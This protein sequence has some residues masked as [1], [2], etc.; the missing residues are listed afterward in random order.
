MTAGQMADTEPND[1]QK[2]RRLNVMVARF[3]DAEA[4]ENN[5]GE[6]NES[7]SD[8]LFDDG[9]IDDAEIK[10]GLHPVTL[11][12]KIVH[13]ESSSQEPQKTALESVVARWEQAATAVRDGAPY[14]TLSEGKVHENVEPLDMSRLCMEPT[15]H[16]IPLW[17]VHVQ[18]SQEYYTLQVI[19]DRLLKHSHLAVAAVV[20]PHVQGSIL[21]ESP[22]LA[23][24]R[25]LC[26]DISSVIHSRDISL[27]P[28]DERVHW[29]ETTR[30][31]QVNE[32]RIPD[33]RRLRSTL[34][35]K[36]TNAICGLDRFGGSLALVC[37]WDKLQPEDGLVLN[38]KILPRVYQPPPWAVYD[39]N[40][41]PP[42]Q[43][44]KRMERLVTPFAW[45]GHPR[46][47]EY[48]PEFFWRPNKNITLED[49]GEGNYI[50]DHIPYAIPFVHFS[51]VPEAYF[52][53]SPPTPTYHELLLFHKGVLHDFTPIPR[54]PYPRDLVPFLEDSWDRYL[55]TP[56]DTGHIVR[57][58]EGQQQTALGMIIS[59][60]FE[61]CDVQLLDTN[62]T[63]KL[64]HSHLRR[65]WKL[66]DGARVVAKMSPHYTQV[67]W[68]IGIDHRRVTLIDRDTKAHFE[69]HT[70]QIE[71]SEIVET[72]RPITPPCDNWKVGDW[73]QTDQSLS[74]QVLQ[75]GRITNIDSGFIALFDPDSQ[76]SCE[77]YPW[78]IEPIERLQQSDV[79][80]SQEQE[81]P[82]RF[83]GGDP[84]RHWVGQRVLILGRNEDK[85]LRG[86]VKQ[87]ATRGLVDV[88][89]DLGA[90]IVRKH[91]SQLDTHYGRHLFSGSP[92]T[93]P[94][95]WSDIDNVYASES[96]TP[97]PTPDQQGESN[98]TRDL[99]SHTTGS[100]GP[101][102]EGQAKEVNPIEKILIRYGDQ[103]LP[104][105]WPLDPALENKR[106]WVYVHNSSPNPVLNEAGYQRGAYDKDRGMIMETQGIHSIKVHISRRR[107]VIDIPARFLFPE[108]PTSAKQTVVVMEGEHKGCV[109]NTRKS[110]VPDHFV[111]VPM[112]GHRLYYTHA[113][114]N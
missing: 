93:T 26:R 19:H 6:H 15:I 27:V 14:G 44:R 88:E 20:S 56:L 77:V 60:E 39:S 23:N 21:V 107:W 43:S 22:N 98:H 51:D 66:G 41:I 71:P 100:S 62:V 114:I 68:V 61:C 86:R 82:G 95:I 106:I 30:M 42:K 1:K 54:P 16:D 63:I 34:F 74:G 113:L 47:S 3:I 12:T 36:S 79:S 111:L 29:L 87:T 64:P 72:I 78:Q 52:E 57:I 31:R 65:H 2:R 112:R 46:Q 109:F 33:W 103:E 55:S 105:D 76:T 17:R 18:T 48:E 110:D 50:I 108:Q 67:G 84:Y 97:L 83:P 59:V 99:S 9:F 24:V 7:D 90:R 28:L 11:P 38:V 85:G 92:L 53:D 81:N 37:G 32:P 4:I 45:P 58:C 89:L 75:Q 101:E 8:S 5:E 104:H 94:W 102:N 69:V 10:E 25:D 73:V 40:I 80:L 13:N 91:I 96:R 49:N 70:W 35:L